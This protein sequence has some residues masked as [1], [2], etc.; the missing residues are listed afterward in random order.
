MKVSEPGMGVANAFHL[1]TLEAEAN[2]SLCVQGLQVQLGLHIKLQESQ[3]SM[4]RPCLKTPK[5]KSN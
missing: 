3:G 5:S 2:G 4:A 1:S